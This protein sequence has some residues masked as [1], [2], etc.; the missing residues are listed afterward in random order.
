[1]EEAAAV[2]RTR[3]EDVS[4]RMLGKLLLL[5][6]AVIVALRT[7]DLLGSVL[8]TIVIATFL[9][10]ALDTVVRALQRKGLS[11]GRA[12]ATVVITIVLGG[13]ILVASAVGLLLSQA[14]RLVKAT[15]AIV[16]DLEASWAWK[17]LESYDLVTPK[18]IDVATKALSTLPGHLL[19]LVSGAVGGV[20]GLVTLLFAVTFLLAGGDRA[21]ILLVRIFPGLADGSGWNLVAATYTNIGQYVVGATLQALAAGGSLL[22]VLLVLG[23]P[24]ALALAMFMLIMDYV[25]LV[26][27]TIGAVPAIGV[28]LFGSSLLDGILVLTFIIVY[29]Q[30]ENAVIQPRIQG[31]VVQLPGVAIFFSV[32]VG[33]SMFGVIGALFAVPIASVI[34]IALQQFFLVTGRDQ[35]HPPRM[36]DDHGRPLA[37]TVAAADA[38]TEATGS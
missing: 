7:L 8:V 35:L 11:R 19:D 30:I 21:V 25:P 15:P 22:L 32:L 23:V 36:F 6:I 17:Q 2:S 29:Q 9:A 20:F 33:G 37:R 12:I 5:A 18:T 4:W 27:A 1:M 14:A 24:Y 26:G 13:V 28:A 31:K 10:I 3:H 34:S 38:A 16:D